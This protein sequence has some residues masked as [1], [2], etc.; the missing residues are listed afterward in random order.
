MPLE[1][2]SKAY[3]RSIVGE[4]RNQG[5]PPCMEDENVCGWDMCHVAKGAHT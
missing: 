4:N 2:E 1:E 3:K 5:I